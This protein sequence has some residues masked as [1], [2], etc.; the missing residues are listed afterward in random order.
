M[1]TMLKGLL[2]AGTTFAGVV[3]LAYASPGERSTHGA[4]DAPAVAQGSS[5]VKSAG[6]IAELAE[7][8]GFTVREMELEHDDG[9]AVYEL[10]ARD[11][12]GNR[13]ELY[14]DARTG[15]RLAGG[16]SDDD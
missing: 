6:E 14:Y 3:T 2:V 9:R 15:E 5:G 11:R 7:R 10:K 1:N 13:H 8:T 12:E 4:P 16:D